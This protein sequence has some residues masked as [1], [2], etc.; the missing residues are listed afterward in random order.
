M[1]RHINHEKIYS[2]IFMNYEYTHYS[3]STNII[4]LD[5]QN[6]VFSLTKVTLRMTRHRYYAT[7]LEVFDLLSGVLFRFT[8]EL[9]SIIF[10]FSHKCF[11]DIGRFKRKGRISMLSSEYLSEISNYHDNI[12]MSC[13]QNYGKTFKYIEDAIFLSIKYVSYITGSLRLPLPLHIVPTHFIT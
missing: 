8:T 10:K 3:S 1:K 6:L 13:F 7:H 11:R 12:K 9:V 4:I 5:A 2:Y